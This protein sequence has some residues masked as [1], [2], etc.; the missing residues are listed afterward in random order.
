MTL[1]FAPRPR[2]FLFPVLFVGALFLGMLAVPD[3]PAATTS[4]APPSLPQEESS[5]QALLD[6]AMTLP[7][8]EAR[9]V[10]RTAADCET[11]PA[12]SQDAYAERE[13]CGMT[14]RFRF[15]GYEGTEGAERLKEM[16]Q[17]RGDRILYA[18]EDAVA[19]MRRLSEGLFLWSRWEPRGEDSQA[20]LVLQAV[21]EA[22]RELVFPM[23]RDGRSEV[24]FYTEHPGDRLMRLDVTAPEADF[25]LE[26]SYRHQTGELTRTVSTQVDCYRVHG[27]LHEIGRVPQYAGPVKWTLRLFDGAEQ[28]QVR[29]R[30][31]SGPPL[32][33][34]QDGDALGGIRLR[35]VSYGR[36][37]V[38]PEFDDSIHHPAFREGALAGD[39]TPLGDSIFWLPPGYWTLLVKP[40]SRD[41]DLE[42]FTRMECHLVPV[43]PERIT[44]VDWPPSLARAFAGGEAGRVE[45]LDVAADSQ[46][47]TVDMALL[48]ADRLGIEASTDN[49]RIYESGAEAPILSVERLKTP[50]DVLL[51]LDSSGSMKHQMS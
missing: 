41:E 26:G 44:V 35:N 39:R 8:I 10:E 3:A 22:D 27:P 43:Q 12:G 42:G 50:L 47:G 24:T 28:V 51:L 19:A 30:W 18:A 5:P 49:V 37:S 6:A 4:P 32:E 33:P 46:A 2:R 40:E 7:G 20:V 11:F 13:V 21:L 38:L 1:R 45:I 48:D 15:S 25:S 36:A 17:A 34:I 29:V 31:S 14:A 23:D 16:L 9:E